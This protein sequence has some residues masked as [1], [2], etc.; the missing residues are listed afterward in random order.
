MVSDVQRR[1]DGV[2][3]GRIG[4][5]GDQ[6]SEEHVAAR[7]HA[8]VERE[9]VHTPSV[10][11]DGQT[12]CDRRRTGRGLYRPV[13]CYGMSQSTAKSDPET[14]GNNKLIPHHRPVTTIL[15]GTS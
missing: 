7:P 5:G 13:V 8:A 3:D 12:A 15:A 11:F 2:E 1:L 6:G 10:G 14:P 9:R 4:A